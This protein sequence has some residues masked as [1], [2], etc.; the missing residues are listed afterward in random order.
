LIVKEHL[1]L[2]FTVLVRNV[3]H[4]LLLVSKIHPIYT[5]AVVRSTWVENLL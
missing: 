1:K 4:V 2:Q 5:E 3:K